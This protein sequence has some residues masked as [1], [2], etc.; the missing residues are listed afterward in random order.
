[1]LA[2]IPAGSMGQAGMSSYYAPAA[3]FGSLS[4]SMAAAAAAAAQQSAM[5]AGLATPTS[6]RKIP[7]RSNVLSVS[8]IAESDTQF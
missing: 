4:A 3:A 2:G 1:M 6:V 7:D 8:I 5:S